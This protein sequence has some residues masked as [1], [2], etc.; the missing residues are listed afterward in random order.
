MCDEL[1]FRHNR[2]SEQL[3]EDINLI[4]PRKSSTMR[5]NGVEDRQVKM[6]LQILKEYLNDHSNRSSNVDSSNRTLSVVDELEAK[7]ILHHFTQDAKVAGNV[8]GDIY[9][10]KFL[11]TLRDAPE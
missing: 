6:S 3:C 11:S 1:V 9:R 7:E 10:N 2:I 5:F 4:E 8:W